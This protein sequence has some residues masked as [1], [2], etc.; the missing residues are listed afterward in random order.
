MKNIISIFI[1][2]FSINTFAQAP[3]KKSKTVLIMN[4]MAHI[5]NGKVI[6]NSAIAFTDGKLTMVADAKAIKLDKSKYDE[7]IDANGKHVYPGI[8]APNI[9]MGLDEIEAVRATLDYA[10]V[11]WLNPNVRAIVA[12]NTDSKVIPT[13]RTNGVLLTQTTPR[14]GLISGSSSV[15][16]LDGWNWEDAAYKMDDGIYLNWPRVM[17]PTGWTEDGPTGWE[18]N[19]NYDKTINDLQKFFDDAKAYR[20]APKTEKNL[21]MEAMKN[22]WSG[23]NLY[24]VANNVKEITEA[25]NFAVANKIAKPV[26]V[27][28]SDAYMVIDLLKK[29]NVSVILQRIHSLPSRTEEDI[30]QPFKTPAQLSAAGILYCLSNEGDMEVMGA[31]NLPF[32]AGTSAAYG[33]TKEQ[34]LMSITLNSAK[35][36]GIDKTCGTLEEGKDAILFISAGDALDM[37]TNNIDKAYIRGVEVDLNNSQKDLCNKYMEKYGLK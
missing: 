4:A 28:A 12:Y 14:G 30:D 22:L 1:L 27:G 31:R 34:A 26:I 21:K 16:A 7:V 24:I 25:V 19:K 33:L 15:M 10:E 23:Q 6:E 2:A 20:D 13:I 18:K 17:V 37:R 29:N 32:Q 8:I 9:K 3:A 36:L 11:G 35:I 5:G